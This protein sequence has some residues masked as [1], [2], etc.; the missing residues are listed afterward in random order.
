VCLPGVFRPQSAE[1]DKLAV[2]LGGANA[3]GPAQR[4]ASK[5]KAAALRLCGAGAMIVVALTDDNSIEC[6]FGGLCRFKNPR[7]NV[8]AFQ[9]LE[10]P[11]FKTFIGGRRA[12]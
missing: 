5:S 2:S 6:H 3:G 8:M 4:S 12:H 11:I 9:A 7:I 10:C 1:S